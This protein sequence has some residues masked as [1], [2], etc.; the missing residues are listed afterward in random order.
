MQL[1]LWVECAKDLCAEKDAQEVL[2]T[3][4]YRH[5]VLLTA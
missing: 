5:C 3:G 2:D 1:R 4:A